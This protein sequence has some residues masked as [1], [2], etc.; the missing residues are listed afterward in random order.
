MKWLNKNLIIECLQELSDEKLQQ[1]LWLSNG[2]P[3]VGSFT[4]AVE[5]LFTDSGLADALDAN[6]MCFDRESDSLLAEL[7]LRIKQVDANSEPLSIISSSNMTVVRDMA[8]R[9]LTR[10]RDQIKNSS[11]ANAHRQ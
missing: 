9:C 10:I 6:E 1:E 7:R 5:Q 8:L 3:F 4:E 11:E 2:P